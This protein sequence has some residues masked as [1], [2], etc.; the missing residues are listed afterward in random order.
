MMHLRSTSLV[1]GALLAASAAGAQQATVKERPLGATIYK[2][3]DLLGAVSAVRGLP[4]GKLLVNDIS[5]RKVVLFDANLENFSI[6]ADT[7]SA[8]ANA[9][10]SRAGGLIPWKS[11]STL[12]VDPNSLSMLV[13]DG[14]GKIARVMSVP[15]ANEAGFLVGG[16]NGTPGTDAQGRLVFRGM[17]DM[18]MMMTRMGGI[19]NGGPG[20]SSATPDSAPLLRMDLAARKL[21][22]IGALQIAKQ[23][24]S[25]TRDDNGRV[26]V[27]ITVNPM[28]VVDDWAIL[29][30]GSIA[31][32]RGKDYHIDWTRPDGSKGS[33]PKISFDWKRMTD[34]DKIA[35]IDS[36]RVA[37][38]KLRSA[39]LSGNPGAVQAGANAVMGGGG[40]Q[41]R[42]QMSGGEA[43]PPQRG[44][45]DGR[46]GPPPADVRGGG[47][48]GV[49]N[50]NV[51]PI[52]MVSPSELPDY[53][54]P[55]T[56]GSARGDLDGNL[57]VRTSKVVNGGSMYDVINTKGELIDRILVP[58]GRVIAGF[59]KDV[60]YMGVREGTG[61]RLEVAKIK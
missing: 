36:S 57:W 47:P 43:M 9:Y 54:P 59:G 2:S 48:G 49:G 4:D 23:N 44:G 53:A 34:D 31:V 56:A 3:K 33:T 14:K 21:D 40:T 20:G 1:A 22:T 30:D 46:G 61:V 37:M 17:Q 52:N 27:N 39:A 32:L 25:V 29:A 58:A 15:R 35:F 60:V 28:P 50:V 6:I 55:F 5:G 16:P 10:S 45:G 42:F 19:A 11:D 51:P 38:E 24:V 18:R 26:S 13:I 41:M 8:T 12:F 7:T